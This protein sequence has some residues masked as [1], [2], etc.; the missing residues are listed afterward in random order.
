MDGWMDGWTG[1]GGRD[2]CMWKE[3]PHYATDSNPCITKN[4]DG[5]HLAHI[6]KSRNGLPFK[7][8]KFNN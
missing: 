6:C 3:L 5:S 2:A 8:L 1:G 7:C 4:Q